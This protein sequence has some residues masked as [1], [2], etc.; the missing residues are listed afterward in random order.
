MSCPCNRVIF[1]MSL[2]HT[3]ETEGEEH[4]HF[5]NDSQVESLVPFFPKLKNQAEPSFELNTHLDI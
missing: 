5:I 1:C 3:W 2:V 4:T